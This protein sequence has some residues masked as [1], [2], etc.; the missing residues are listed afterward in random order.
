MD[1]HSPHPAQ[2]HQAELH[3]ESRAAQWARGA[4]YRF[5]P[6][7]R[8][9]KS[10]LGKNLVY[11]LRV[12]REV[13][14]PLAFALGEMQ[15]DGVATLVLRRSE[16]TVHVRRRSGDLVMLH[17][18][19]GRDIYLP[20]PEVE[21]RLAQV[22]G[23]LRAAD[24]G[25]NVG[26]FT[27]RLLER[28]PDSLIYAV[29]ADPHN[30]ALFARTLETNRLKEQV[31]LAEA[32]ASNRPGAVEF[33]AGNFFQSR[34]VDGEGADTVLVQMIDVLPRLADRHL[35]KI[36]IEGSEWPILLDERFRNLEAVALAMEWHAHGCPS[37]D[38][39]AAAENALV[40]AGFTVRH[41][42]S[43]A[44]CGTLWAWR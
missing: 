33:A 31:E 19:L 3:G 44:D 42:S 16:M 29:E 6:L 32:A 17:Q 35:I 13:K 30:A 36:D 14:R 5:G 9:V 7:R 39:R 11:T 12:S 26:F 38:P 20:P 22:D 2:A 25:G 15:A 1:Q 10:E 40:E 4:I 41:S 43:D 37:A 27:M 28:Y 8:L 18:I 24:L 21:E 34:V 23:P